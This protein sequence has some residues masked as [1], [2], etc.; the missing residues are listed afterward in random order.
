VTPE[1]RER[2]RAWWVRVCSFLSTAD[3]RKVESLAKELAAA[4]SSVL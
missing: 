3:D 4:R 2:A 1:D